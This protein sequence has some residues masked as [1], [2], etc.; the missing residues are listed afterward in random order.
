MSSHVFVKPELYRYWLKITSWQRQSDVA[1][2]LCV[3]WEGG[4]SRISSVSALSFTFLSSPFLASYHLLVFFCPFSAFLWKM[5]KSPARVDLSLNKNSNKRF[6]YS[7]LITFH[8]C[9]PSM[10]VCN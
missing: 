2:T 7:V 6:S 10:A 3:Y 9:V 4:H 5:A 8:P 1:T